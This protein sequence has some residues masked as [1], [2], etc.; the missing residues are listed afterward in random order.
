MLTWFLGLPS[1]GYGAGLAPCI[2]TG[3]A[4]GPPVVRCWTLCLEVL[5]GVVRTPGSEHCGRWRRWL[6]GGWLCV[7]HSQFGLPRS[8]LHPSSR[9]DTWA[10]WEAQMLC[11]SALAN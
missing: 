6:Q 11:L 4:E 10:V 2:G 8:I 9:K 5:W 7:L 3:R 1:T